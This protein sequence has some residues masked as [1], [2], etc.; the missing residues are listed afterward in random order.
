MCVGDFYRVFL[1]YLCLFYR[2]LS[3]QGVS[4]LYIIL[5]VYVSHF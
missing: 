3:I 2:D 4:I 1:I 5:L